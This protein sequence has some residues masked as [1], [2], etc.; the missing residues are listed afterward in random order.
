[1][2]AVEGTWSKVASSGLLVPP[3]RAGAALNAVGSKLYLFGG[4]NQDDAWLQDLYIFDTGKQ[5]E[6]MKYTTSCSSYMYL[7]VCSDVVMVAVVR[8]RIASLSSRQDG[9]GCDWMQDL[10]LRRLRASGHD[11]FR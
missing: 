2:F 6:R 10:L 9:V 1:M 3:A 4:F 8:R 11:G 5:G 7:F